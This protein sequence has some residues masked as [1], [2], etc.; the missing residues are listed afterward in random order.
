MIYK[1]KII[2]KN[3]IG[4]IT[5]D[6][7][8]NTFY[9]AKNS[10]Q[11]YKFVLH[12]KYI[13]LIWP[14]KKIRLYTTNGGIIYKRSPF[15]YLE[16]IDKNNILV[17]PNK[18]KEKNIQNPKEIKIS[19][20]FITNLQNKFI[21]F[22]PYC[23]V[24]EKF[25]IECLQSIENQ[26]YTNYSV[27]IINDGSQKT[28]HI[29][30]FISEKNNY[31]LINFD[32]N[33]GPGHS[34]WRFV[35]HIQHNIN[36]YESNDVVII[37][38][39]D[40][41]L[42]TNNAF[43]I[44][45]NT[46]IKTSCWLTYGNYI[47]KFNSSEQYNGNINNLRK[48]KWVFSHPIT[49]KL[50]LIKHLTRNIFMYNDEYIKKSSDR[51]F[52]YPLI[53]LCGKD[54]IKYINEKIYFYREHTLNLYKTISNEYN[55]KVTD[56]IKNLPK[57]QQLKRYI[58]IILCTYNRNNSLVHCL[59]SLDEQIN[60]HNIIVH[61][62][63][64]NINNKDINQITS[65]FKNIKIITYDNIIN[66]HC[67]Y[68]IY[69]A[70]NL[71]KKYLLDKVII[72][73]DDQYY[74]KNW[75]AKMIELYR[76][77]CVCSWY[78]KQFNT[79]KPNYWNPTITYDNIIAGNKKDIKNWKYFG[80][81]GC[82]I[83]T[84]LFLYNELDRF[85]NY[86]NDII[87]IDDLF[88][89]YIF[90]KHLNIKFNRIFS[91]PS[92][93]ELDD[94]NRTW[95]SIKDQKN[96]L[97]NSF[98]K[99]YGWDV[100]MKTNNF[101]TIN[102]YFDKIYILNLK[103]ETSKR[104][105]C[106]DQLINYNINAT[107]FEGH[108]GSNCVDCINFMKEFKSRKIN[109]IRNHKLQKHFIKND[110]YTRFLIRTEGTLGIMKSMIN[111]FQDAKKNNYEKILVLQDDFVLHKHFNTLF[112]KY[113]RNIPK[114]WHILNLSSTHWTWDSVDKSTFT[115]KY[116]KCISTTYGAV[117]SAYRKN[118]YDVIISLLDKLNCSFDTF[119]SVDIYP[120]KKYN[121]Y[122]MYPNL[123]IADITCSASGKPS[124][125]LFEITNGYDPKKLKWNIE[126][127]NY[128]KYWN[129]NVSL[130]IIGCEKD[131]ENS[132]LIKSIE[133][134]NY[135]NLQ[136]KYIQ[137]INEIN[138]NVEYFMILNNKNCILDINL[139]P[140]MLTSIKK[141]GI[142]KTKCKKII[143]NHDIDLEN[144]ELMCKYIPYYKDYTEIDDEDMNRFMFKGKQQIKDIDITNRNIKC[145]LINTNTI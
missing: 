121:C 138:D 40:D 73:D 82:I 120:K 112:D 38:D 133:K 48:E 77:L 76:P 89:S 115:K 28:D 139:V 88:M 2:Y 43:K 68:R 59:K 52:I 16:A 109:D 50:E 93:V 110:Q 47:G 63:N 58:H 6:D 45:N 108:D 11:K 53:E 75:V 67:Y 8:N 64:N 34:K 101:I 29:K 105:K 79:N 41:Y 20:K 4:E 90:D 106:R 36:N 130:F 140:N 122:T 91:C 17:P 70:K 126:Q 55:T 124:R 74:N 27:I 97:F 7:D 13:I 141:Q 57:L 119:I 69:F 83:D 39:G 85:E 5:L 24:Y 92:K 98:I 132:L 18:K 84:N 22:V 117:A 144:Y 137:S 71:L 51:A 72:I 100:K 114:N 25:I 129:I 9:S 135:Y 134:H 113:I 60:A 127:Y 95:I 32:K 65:Q 10:H 80:P 102:E 26:N 1:Y 35:E 87:K 86:D 142:D 128:K 143:L 62:I 103:K 3:I 30:Y 19:N 123:I 125:D 66:Y 46:Y 37:L 42:Y 54:K 15:Y 14:D 78:G 61:L 49:F 94:D 33:Y 116:Y 104:N 99:N 31:T 12:G 56:Y 21:V 23:D 111:I 136:I 81:G 145:M 131:Y 118:M 96:N 107:F 44:I